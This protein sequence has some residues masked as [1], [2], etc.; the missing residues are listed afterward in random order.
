[1]TPEKNY[2]QQ[3]LIYKMENQSAVIGIIGLGY[4]GLPLSKAYISKAY[5][6]KAYISKGYKVIGFDIDD[7][8]ADY[9]SKGESYIEHVDMTDLKSAYDKELFIPTSDFSRIAEVDA[10]VICVPTPLNTHREPDISFVISSLKSVL[11]WLK[12]GQVLSLE[13]TTYPGTTE[14]ELRPPIEQ[15]GLTIGDD[16]FL[17]YSP[18]REDPNNPRYTTQ[19]IP[20]VCGGSTPACLEVGKALYEKVIEGIVEVSSSQAAEMSK[21]LENTFRA[22]NIALVNEFKL[23][24]EKMGIDIFE[25]IRAG[26]VGSQRHF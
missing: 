21:I 12:K 23:I 3:G 11:P 8:K 20:K 24:S 25:V 9:I 10:V 15:Q 2:I 1:M 4:V 7:S 6:S 16:F 19:S 5:I 13:S 18:E 26:F 22:V 17:V 14:E